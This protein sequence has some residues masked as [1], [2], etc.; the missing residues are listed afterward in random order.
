MRGARSGLPSPT[1][2]SGEVGN[3]LDSDAQSGEFTVTAKQDVCSDQ[4]AETV[5]S[6]KDRNDRSTVLLSAPFPL[7]WVLSYILW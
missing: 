5:E 3:Y 7:P 2:S 1:E 6:R 4:Q